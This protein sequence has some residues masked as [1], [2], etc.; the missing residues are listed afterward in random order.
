MSRNRY[1]DRPGYR[2]VIIGAAI[3]VMV[4]ALVLA[5]AGLGDV[6]DFGTAVASQTGVIS[7]RQADSVRRSAR[8]VERSA[9]DIT[10]EQEYYIGRSVGAVIT[11]RYEL[12]ED[13]EA[14]RYIN[15]LG[16]SL[17]LFSRRPE[18]FGGYRFQIL[19]S[20]EINAFATP[21]GIVFVTRGLLNLASSEDGVASI[22]AH[23][24]G[25][26]E[27]QHGLQA[28]RTSRITAALTSVAI[29]GTQFATSEDLAELTA[30]FEDSI[31]DITQTLINSGYSRSAEREADRA[32]VR[33][34]KRA[35]YDPAGLIAVL[36]EMDLRLDPRG[37]DF[38][39][40]HPAPDSRISDIR[41]EIDGY[42]HTARA[43]DAREER[44]RAALGRL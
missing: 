7:E 29:T 9:E 1:R 6:A 31:D 28:I 8:A 19:D 2:A 24:I 42:S 25:H 11:D 20:D 33:I 40:T 41:D 14:N 43:T 34:M 39:A 37:L 17:A 3:A 12:Y 44:Y 30:T 16:Q 27:Y 18:T 38:A 13:E 15:T 22:L 32:A 21:S 26:I 4:M 36:E 5:C 23:E 10:P 35:G